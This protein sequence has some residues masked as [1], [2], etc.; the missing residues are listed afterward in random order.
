[1]RDD[2]AE[3]TPETAPAGRPGAGR[4]PGA[5]A[6]LPMPPLG[7]V[8]VLGALRRHRLPLAACVVLVP[9]LALLALHQV[10][11]LY[12][13][14]GTV[15]YDDRGYAAHELQSVLR[16]DP[17][18][19]AV[20]ASQA[21]ILHGL[22]ITERITDRLGLDRDP[23]FNAALRPPG[24]L[25]RASAAAHRIAGQLALMIAPGLG[26]SWLAPKAPDPQAARRNTLLAVQD[27]IAVSTVKASHVLDVAFTAHDPTLAAEAVNLAMGFYIQDQLDAKIDAV[28]RATAWLDDR[29]AQLRAE[30]RQAEDRIATYRAAHGL[31]QGVRAGLDTERIS[32]L[33]ED[34]LSSR[35]EL[36]AAQ[37]RLDAARGQLGAPAQAGVAPSVVQARAQRD[38]LAGQLQALSAHA[39]R[40]YPDV[41]SMRQQLAEAD[42]AVAN[43]TA[44]VVAAAAA[45]LRADRNRVALLEDALR[46]AQAEQDRGDAAQVTL[47]AMQRD[48]DAARTLLQSVQSGMQQ[49]AQQTAIE[50]AD[51]RIISRALP[52][53]DPSY[54]RRGPLLGA[55]AA[56]GVL[57]GLLLV[58]LLELADGTVRSG[59]DVRRHLGLRCLALIPEI[60]RRTLAGGRVHEYALQKPL[61]PFAEQIRAL[62]AGLWMERMRP[63][64]VAFTAARPSEGKTTVTLALARCAAL[65]GERV[66]VVDCDVRQP[67]IGRMFG[68]DGGSGLIDCLQGRATLADVT[69]RDAATGLTVIPAGSLDVNALSMFM[70]PTMAEL[71]QRLRQ[72]YDLILLDAPPAH[73]ITDARVIAGMA[74]ATVLCLRW[75]STPIGVVRDALGLLEEAQASVVGVAL[76]RVD[77]RAHVRS[78]YSDAEVYQPRYGGYFRE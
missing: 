78:G 44:R 16:V 4:A 28:R 30:V 19:D 21:E 15:L 36:A 5:T 10:T 42:R 58:H 35:N 37:G 76:T 54:P 70:S 63:R 47:N 74:E 52:P 29:V 18:T 32:R 1:M 34:L 59:D 38:L 17:M 73:A 3:L 2:P 39:G 27:A 11:P 43:E 51:S 50:T 45:D 55:A 57:F 40:N 8:A 24:A 33:N 61:S 56:F 49:T 62:R 71:L 68:I 60:G 7:A 9:L 20:M 22:S 65:C 14:S 31:S 25:A 41:V 66:V 13:A 69:C 72:D 48:A 64:I 53:A 23:A 67:S 26:A 6:W 12:T 75:H 77:V 46:Q